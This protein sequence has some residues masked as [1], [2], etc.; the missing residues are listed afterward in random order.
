M[1]SE[2]TTSH[3]DVILCTLYGLVE[4]A[5]LLNYG[6]SDKHSSILSEVKDQSDAVEEWKREL[7]SHEQT[8]AAAVNDWVDGWFASSHQGGNGS[9]SKDIKRG[10]VETYLSGPYPATSTQRVLTIRTSLQS[11]CHGS[12]G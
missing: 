8:D 7:A 3:L 5:Y 10:N 2:N 12:P 11:R 6:S 9:H 4:V 1:I